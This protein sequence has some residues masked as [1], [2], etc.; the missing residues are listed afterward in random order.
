MWCQVYTSVKYRAANRQLIATM[1]RA[2]YHANIE[3][4][5][6][7]KRA[8]Y[9]ADPKK[10]CAQK[11]ARYC[12]EKEAERYHRYY[13]K[14][15]DKKNASQKARYYAN[16]DREIARAKDDVTVRRRLI[17][18]Q[19]IAMAHRKE[20]RAFIRACPPGYHVDHQVPLRGKNV[21]GL[22]VPWNLQYLPA[23]INRS[24][25]NRFGVV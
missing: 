12:P 18:G 23:A 4:I 10:V 9:A 15:K 19:K 13:I 21:C 3:K 7:Q 2:R 8:R 1:A 25:G 6:S 17:G 20:T 16:R 14:N 24:K 22:H 5:R 11:K